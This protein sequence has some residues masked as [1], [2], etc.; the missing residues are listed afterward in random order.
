MRRGLLNASEEVADFSDTGPGTLTHR[1]PDAYVHDVLTP[2]SGSTQIHEACLQ[3][4]L[5]VS[6][7]FGDWDSACVRCPDVDF[8][9]FLVWLLVDGR[10]NLVL[11][12]ASKARRQCV[13][14]NR[15]LRLMVLA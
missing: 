3:N 13:A 6:I 1:G 5:T 4:G 11:L 15:L 9:D 7:P 10:V 2:C 14:A 8:L 12:Y